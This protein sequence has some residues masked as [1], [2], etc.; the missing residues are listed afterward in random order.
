MNK[1]ALALIGATLSAAVSAQGSE[2][3]VASSTL[4][5]TAITV[6][7]PLVLL[8]AVT[9]AAEDNDTPTAPQTTPSTITA[10]STSTRTR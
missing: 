1:L 8:T 5:T 6:A 7:A 9:V 3:T 2:T 10:T 4:L